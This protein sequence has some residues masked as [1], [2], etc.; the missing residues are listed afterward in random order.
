MRVAVNANFR[1]S[2]LLF[3]HCKVQGAQVSGLFDTGAEVTLADINLFGG[4]DLPR[5]P[6]VNIPVTV[7]GTPLKVRG[8][9]LVTFE[10]DGVSI[11]NHMIYLVDGL[12]VACLIGTDLMARF[13]GVI[14]LDL[15]RKTVTVGSQS[16]VEEQVG[17]SK[18]QVGMP[19][20]RVSTFAGQTLVEEQVGTPMGQMATSKGQV[21]MPI[22]RVSTSTGQVTLPSAGQ[23]SKAGLNEG[24]PRLRL[25]GRVRLVAP[26]DIPAGHEA[27]LKAVVDPGT[28]EGT[29]LIEP[30]QSLHKKE[31]VIGA[32]ALVT[33][34]GAHVQVRLVN[35]SRRTV[36]LK[37]GMSIAKAEVL[38]ANTVVSSVVDDDHD[39]DMMVGRPNE[40]TGSELEMLDDMVKCSEVDVSDQE[41]LRI[42][43]QQNRD[44]FSLQG[45]LGCT[46]LVEHHIHTSD[47]APIRQQPRRIPHHLLGEVDRQIDDMLTRGLIQES[48]SPWASP[49]VL[50]KKRNGEVRFCIDYRGLNQVS[51]HDAYPVPRVDDALRGLK[52]ARWFST[53]DLASAY[54]QIPMDSESSRKAAFTTHRGLFE[55]KRMP[56]GLRSAPATMQR[57]M[58]TLFGSMNWKMV[59]VYLDDIVIY[60]ES[61]VQ[62]LARM[63]MVFA[64][65]RE[66][67]LKLKPSKCQF[68]RRKVEYLGHVVSSEGISTSPR[69]VQAVLEYKTPQDVTAVRRFLGMA[70]YYRSFIGGCSDITEPLN[71]LTRKHAR[72]IWNEECEAAF[73]LLKHRLATAPVLHFPDFSLKFHLTTDASEIGVGGVLSQRVENQDCPIGYFSKALSRA[74]Q[75]YSA[76]DR[77]CLA[78]VAAIEHFD[79]FLS[80]APFIVHSD[81]RPLSYL[82]SLKEPRGRLARWVLFLS[83]YD[84]EIHYKPGTDIPH[85]DALSRSVSSRVMSTI[86]EPRW[87]PGVLRDAQVADPIIGKVLYLMRMGKDGNPAEGGRELRDLL[88]QRKR[89]SLSKEGVLMVKTPHGNHQVVLPAQMVREVLSVAH[90]LPASGHLGSDKTLE[91]VRARFYWPTLF[92]DVSRYCR[93]CPSC[94]KLKD[95]ARTRR[96]PLQKMPVPTRPFEFISIDHAGPL[97]WTTKKNRYI[98]VISCLFSKWVECIAV[99]SMEASVVAEVLLQEV[100]CR[101]GVPRRL[102]SDQGRSFESAIIQHLCKLLG[103]EKSR[104]SAYHP[105]SN[106]QTERFNHTMK[107][108]LSH[109]VNQLTHKD[110]DVYLPLVLFAYRTSK[111]A[112]TNFTPFE[113]VFC[114]PPRIP[115]DCLLGNPGLVPSEDPVGDVLG[116]QEKIPEVMK[117][118]RSYIHKGQDQRNDRCQPDNFRP[119]RVGDYVMVSNTRTKKGLAKKL[120]LD[121]WRGP[122]RVIKVVSDVT[123]RLKKGQ[124]KILVHYNRLKPFHEP[125]SDFDDLSSLDQD[126]GPRLQHDMVLGSSQHNSL[127]MEAAADECQRYDIDES[128]GGQTQLVI[129]G[130]SDQL[131]EAPPVI[132]PDA[133]LVA[134]PN[135]PPVAPPPVMV[136]GGRLWCNVKPENIISGSR[137]RRR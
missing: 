95:P 128:L 105:E 73:Q 77:E 102:H 134:P 13:P 1:S 136:Q 93:T 116:L 27:L 26:A 38:P 88:K 63:Q 8:A 110:W 28:A 36:S 22:G 76:T 78:I 3:V 60:S 85:A 12:G 19:I 33:P 32:R 100:V 90:D 55:P 51:N 21:S 126:I 108:M 64:K 127:P 97:P 9:V 117:L 5:V 119:Y 113:L 66:A 135:V 65:I 31:G 130:A 132:P 7:D 75:N 34:D 54:W 62:H 11:P 107:N 39:L 120:R 133:P 94:Q 10:V 81:H 25:I 125:R 89:L 44:V 48:T 109:Y 92:R 83:S 122:Y 79:M 114:R 20:G 61:V 70:G 131:Q 42:C 91:K 98:L 86:L 68:L 52:G 71:K 72:F 69:V 121:R 17:T 103:I 41:A 87:A 45:E 137:S 99:K 59:L 67:H 14:V 57:L 50:A 49:V 112:T 35:V 46:P 123:Y 101:Y 53:L 47:C 43:L 40:V 29:L 106:G 82:R 2:N 30:Y 118:V 23:V 80:G 96:A 84:F 4:Q 58:T 37:A 56:F 111:H 104:T 129:E 24:D 6:Y 115:L 74:Q 15:K 124:Q 16:Q 18:G